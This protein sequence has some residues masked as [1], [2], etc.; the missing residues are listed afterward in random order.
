[1]KQELNSLVRMPIAISSESQVLSSPFLWGEHGANTVLWWCFWATG[2]YWVRNVT[3]CIYHFVTMFIFVSK[4]P[5]HVK[6]ESGR[7]YLYF[8]SKD[9]T[10]IPKRLREL[11]RLSLLVGG[12]TWI[13]SW[14]IACFWR[15]SF[16]LKKWQGRIRHV[17]GTDWFHMGAGDEWESKH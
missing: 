7:W 1:M 9:S 4:F 12:L 13:I 11:L 14:G 2:Q 6:T 15:H 16:P 8:L 3:G 17:Q 5:P 10:V